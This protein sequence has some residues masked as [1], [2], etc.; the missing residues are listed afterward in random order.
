[1][2]SLL[3]LGSG[4]YAAGVRLGH[5]HQGARLSCLALQELDEVASELLGF[6][7]ILHGQD[8]LFGFALAVTDFDDDSVCIVVS[9][10]VDGGGKRVCA[11]G[12]RGF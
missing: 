2:P 7:F 11:F 12:S 8:L 5:N 9:Q 10:R 1:M 6:G 4:N 3:G